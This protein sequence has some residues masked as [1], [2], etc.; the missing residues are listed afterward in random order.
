MMYKIPLGIDK[1]R[2]PIIGN[3]LFCDKTGLIAEF[4]DQG[5]KVT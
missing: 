2:E 3:F 1:F 4:L 5:S